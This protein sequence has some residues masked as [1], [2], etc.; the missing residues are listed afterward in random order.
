MKPEEI[1]IATNVPE[2]DQ[3]GIQH[4]G[5]EEPPHTGPVCEEPSTVQLGAT[6]EQV[7]TEFLLGKGYR[8]VERNFRC[9]IGELDVVARDAA[10]TLC[11]IEVRSRKNFDYGNAAETVNATKRRKVTRAAKAYLFF[12]R[13]EFDTARFDVV[14]ITGGQ[15]DLIVDAWRL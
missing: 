11:F 15:I 1:T 10:G 3:L 12:R 14:A 7:A 5:H 6:A 8:I 13:P 4:D 2:N 9:K